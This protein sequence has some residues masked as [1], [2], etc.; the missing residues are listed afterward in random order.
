MGVDRVLDLGHTS[1]HT[2]EERYLVVRVSEGVENWYAQV[3]EIV[4]D[5][6]P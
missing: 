6:T 5:A 1:Y 4:G 2:D 3:V